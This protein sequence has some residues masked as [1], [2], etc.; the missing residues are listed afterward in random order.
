[1]RWSAA[2]RLIQRSLLM[3]IRLLRWLSWERRGCSPC[4]MSTSAL[5]CGA[6]SKNRHAPVRC[7]APQPPSARRRACAAAAAKHMFHMTAL[8]TN[9]HAHIL[10][11][12]EHPYFD[13]F[14]HLQALTSIQEGDILRRGHDDG[15]A[16]RNALRQRE[17]DVARTGRHVD[18]K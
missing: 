8:T 15:A 16:H 4:S 17:L 1:M 14:K 6:P 12:A 11:D 2:M 13:L 7:P 9:V 18:R 3:L 10:H 5:P